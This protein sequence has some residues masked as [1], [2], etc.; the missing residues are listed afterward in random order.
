MWR[1]ARRLGAPPRRSAPN[2]LRAMT[3]PT[4]SPPTRGRGH[5]RSLARSREAGGTQLRRPPRRRARPRAPRDRRGRVRRMLQRRRRCKPSATSD[6]PTSASAGSLLVPVEQGFR[7]A[8][9]VNPAQRKST[10]PESGPN[11]TQMVARLRRLAALD[12]R[13]P[14]ER[15]P[16]RPAFAELRRRVGRRRPASSRAPRESRPRT[17]GRSPPTPAGASPATR[18]LPWP[19]STR[20]DASAGSSLE[21]E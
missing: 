3:I 13:E 1:E 18:A 19:R 17:T 15:H 4:P 14:G 6:R 8:G 16:E 2:R 5:D 21:R 10:P 11:S 9:G 12:S 7:M 20:A